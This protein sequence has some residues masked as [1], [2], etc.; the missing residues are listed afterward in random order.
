[1]SKYESFSRDREYSLLMNRYQS[2]IPDPQSFKEVINTPLPKSFWFNSLK[3]DP[4]EYTSVLA[5]EGMSVR[6][7]P[8]CIDGFRLKSAEVL[9]RSWLYRVGLIQIQEEVSMLPGYI[10]DPKP[11]ERVLDLCAA[12]GNKTS[13]LSVLMQNTGVLVANDINYNRLKALGSSIRRLGLI[14]INLTVNNGVHFPVEEAYFDKILVD[15]PCSCEGTL[16]KNNT[17]NMQFTQSNSEHIAE[18]QIALMKKAYRLLRPGGLLVYSTCTFAP[19]E[20]EAVV[21]TLIKYSK[22]KMKCIPITLGN[23]NYNPGLDQWQG[24]NYHSSLRYA[25]RIWP[26]LNNTGG[27]FVALLRKQGEALVDNVG[28]DP[29]LNFDLGVE[30][31]IKSLQ[32]HFEIENEYLDDLRFYQPG[33][34]GIFVTNGDNV[35][36]QESALRSVSFDASGLFFL[37]TKI[38]FP[39]ITSGAAM[40]L[41]EGV[42]ANMVQLTRDQMTDFCQ[43]KDIFVLRKQLIKCSGTGYLV[44][45]YGKYFLGV[46]VLFWRDKDDLMPVRSLFPAYLQ[47]S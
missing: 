41:G 19:E 32:K 7:M 3:V 28:V 37:K 16:R 44:V 40:W 42:R 14:N 43:R 4:S 1:M 11:G 39:K 9:G 20:N 22:E 15:A 24:R 29:R 35:S 46:G 26:E 47:T 34:R 27:F 18:T 23:F 12:P 45:K 31:H 10:L 17:R 21:D 36:A 8:W 2:I 33:K 5:E 6:S 38:R 13:Q 25:W 30:Q